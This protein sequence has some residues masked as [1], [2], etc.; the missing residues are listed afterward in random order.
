MLDDA[1]AN[2]EGEVEPAKGR[3]ALFKPGDDAQGVQVVVEAEA[4]G[5]QG[6]VEGFFA[7]VAEGRMADVVR[8]GERFGESAFRPRAAA[9]VREIWVTSSV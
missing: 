7:S 6:V 5:A 3:I 2:A 8:Q 4:V 9:R 1:F